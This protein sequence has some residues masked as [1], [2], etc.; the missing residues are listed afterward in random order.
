[1]TWAIFPALGFLKTGFY[2]VPQAGLEFIIL[3]PFPLEHWDQRLGSPSQTQSPSFL[4][5]KKKP[6]SEKYRLFKTI[7]YRRQFLNSGSGKVQLQLG[8]GEKVFV[9]LGEHKRLAEVTTISRA[10]LAFM[11]PSFHVSLLVSLLTPLALKSKLWRYSGLD[12]RLKCVSMLGK[13]F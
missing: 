13:M 3:L 5:N 10:S 8:T 6:K 9:F 11:T 4:T 1:M 7:M 12:R 2:Y